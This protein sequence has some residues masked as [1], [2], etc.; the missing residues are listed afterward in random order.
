MLERGMHSCE[1]ECSRMPLDALLQELDFSI[2]EVIGR[3]H[4]LELVVNSDSEFRISDLI[5]TGMTL[6]AQACTA[7]Y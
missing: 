5:Y 6:V 7:L 4:V 3:C 2:V 1:L